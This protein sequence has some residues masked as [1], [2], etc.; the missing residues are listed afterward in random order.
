MKQRDVIKLL[1]QQGYYLLRDQGNHMVFTIDNPA[2]NQQKRIS[3]PRHTEL[4][5][6]TARAILKQA[7]L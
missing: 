3:V 7:G 6:T 4:K 2:S 5:E 1:K